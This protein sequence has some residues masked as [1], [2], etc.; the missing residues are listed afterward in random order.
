MLMQR[1][2]VFE[3]RHSDARLASSF[4][5]ILK[6]NGHKAHCTRPRAPVGLRK[7]C[8]NFM[9]KQACIKLSIPSL[10]R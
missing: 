4:G 2:S 3:F 10:L 6:N 9:I 7:S 1:M 8:L 5:I